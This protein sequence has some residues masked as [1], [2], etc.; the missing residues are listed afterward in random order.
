ME[1]FFIL[2]YETLSIL[3]SVFE[4]SDILNFSRVSLSAR[5][6]VEQYVSVLLIDSNFWNDE[7][8][9]ENQNYDDM[10]ADDSFYANDEKITEEMTPYG[11]FTKSTLIK[12]RKGILGLLR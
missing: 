1:N 9:K 7:E 3:L 10:F 2:D 4:F 6:F 5:N 11:N 12:Y 8:N